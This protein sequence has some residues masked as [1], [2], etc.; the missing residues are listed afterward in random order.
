MSGVT[1]HLKPD[2]WL[3]ERLGRETYRLTVDEA[4]LDPAGEA[5]RDALLA[6]LNRPAFVY[7]KVS[8]TFM[9]GL[10]FLQRHDFRL[11]D[12]NVIFEKKA[13]PGRQETEDSGVRL[14][15]PSDR[16]ATVELARSSFRYSRFHLDPQIPRE[17][18]DR[19]KADWVAAYFA[20]TRGHQMVVIQVDE[21]VAGFLQLLRAADGSLV[22]D[23][24]AVDERYRRR[25]LGAE[26]IAFVE[27]RTRAGEL[28][29]VG[30]QIAN[31][32]SVRLYESAG[33][34]MTEA[35]YVF[36]YHHA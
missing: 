29:R 10:R 17:T 5:E 31:I 34:R 24:I 36:H 2:A 30:T 11:V 21:E 32:A 18:A 4:L 16:D 28:I 27:S 6:I 12:T 20:G 14:A 26:M 1:D 7:T 25:G 9:E 33:F 3:A 22:I 13:Y 19:I 15:K 23:L 8:P 35:Q